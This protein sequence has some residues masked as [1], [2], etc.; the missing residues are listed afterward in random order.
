MLSKKHFQ[1]I[2]G[3]LKEHNETVE[4]FDGY[5]CI[6]NDFADFLKT[7]NKDFNRETFLNA[8]GVNEN[9]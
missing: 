4:R 2:A 6:C 8:C 9:D 5:F 1:K 3:I 7:T